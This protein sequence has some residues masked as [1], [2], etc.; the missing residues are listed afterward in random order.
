MDAFKKRLD[1]TKPFPV[2][3]WSEAKKIKVVNSVRNYP[4]ALDE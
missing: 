3:P 4:E 2:T 1:T